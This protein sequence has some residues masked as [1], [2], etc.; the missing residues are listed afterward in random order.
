MT[1][2][3]RSDE[4]GVLATAEITQVEGKDLAQSEIRSA[5]STR[6]S[7][8]VLVPQHQGRRV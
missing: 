3:P 7:S 6:T 2:W 8:G 5:C 4:I 1:D